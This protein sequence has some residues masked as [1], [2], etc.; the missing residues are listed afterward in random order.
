MKK[1]EYKK[2]N[3]NTIME[4]DEEHDDSANASSLEGPSSSSPLNSQAAAAPTE[5]TVRIKRRAKKPRPCRKPSKYN[6]RV[7]CVPGK[8]DGRTGQLPNEK[9]TRDDDEVV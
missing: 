6:A 9:A 5:N 4:E 8:F 1:K 7:K 2:Y 3:T